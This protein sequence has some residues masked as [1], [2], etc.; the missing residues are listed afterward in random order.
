MSPKS[1]QSAFF[2]SMTDPQAFRLMFDQQP[3]VFFFV[4]DRESR[5][6]AA[7]EP[8]W[9][10]L[11]LESEA[12]VIG[13]LD[14]DFYPEQAAKSFRADDALVFR[15][16]KPLINR[17]EVW[18][19]EQRTLTW[20][21]T[22]KVPLRGK[23]GKIIGLMGFTRRDEG[24]SRH[25]PRSEVTLIVSHIQK[26]TNRILSTVEL[27]R[28]CSLSERTLYRKIHQALGVTPYELMLRIR[29]ESAAEA[30][31]QTTDKVIDI[32]QAHAFC[33]QSAF[34]Q[35]FR[36]RIGLTPKQFRLRHQ[37]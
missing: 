24:R 34:T 5:L 15:T 20:F 32:A 22:T 14:E 30:L 8:M 27:A 31:I 11:G 17:L 25:Q 16:G 3:N 2:A 13:R 36:K 19:D 28:E 21:L 6:I 23:N 12:D 26:N 7:S 10:R 29:I 4:K 37:G 18:Y 1:L 9:T 35:H 33:D